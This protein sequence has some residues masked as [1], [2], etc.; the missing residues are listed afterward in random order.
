ELLAR[1]PRIDV[2]VNNA[3]LL[4]SERNETKD[5]F[6]TTFGVNHLW[7]FLLTNLLLDR[8][9]ASEPARIVNVASR[10]H[11][12]VAGLDFDDLQGRRG[13]SPFRAYCAS[14]LANVLF[15]LELARRLA[16]TRVTANSLHPGTVRSGFMADG[17]A[18]GLLRI[19][20]AL[21]RPFMLSS[22][23]GAQTSIYL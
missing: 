12:R 13:Y 20:W 16:G 22:E 5:G 17:D 4:Q 10:A 19:G 15:T 14:K 18:K 23:Q 7:P 6:E 3:G 1:Q 2:L 9:R 11:T 21:I 8:L